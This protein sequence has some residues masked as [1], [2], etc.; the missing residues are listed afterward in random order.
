MFA[1]AQRRIAGVFYVAVQLNDQLFVN[2]KSEQDWKAGNI[3]SCFPYVHLLTW[4]SISIRR[5][6]G[7]LEST[8]QGC[9]PERLGFPRLD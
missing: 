3:T 8:A 5:Q 6:S 7:R 1:Q 4:R 9:Q 2:L